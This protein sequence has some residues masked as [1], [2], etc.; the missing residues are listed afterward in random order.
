[1]TRQHGTRARYVR[2]PDENGQPGKGCRCDACRAANA[3]AER[4]K[5]RLRAYGRWRPLVDAGPVREH[6]AVLAGRGIKTKR[7]SQLS[8]ISHPAIVRIAE[9][10]T[11]RVRAQTA[12]A[13]L[14]VQPSPDLLTPR[15]HVDGAGT[16]RRLQALV[17]VGWTRSKL[18]EHI[19]IH[20]TNL[21]GIVT[22]D[23]VRADTARKVAA[24]YDALWD[25]QPPMGT[26]A[27]RRAAA[28]ARREAAEKGWLPPAAWDDDLIDL[29]DDELEVEL[30]RRV[31]AMDDAE[32]AR[33]HHA[34]YKLGELSPLVAAAARLYNA[35]NNRRRLA[36]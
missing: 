33:C 12:E 7:V 10:R 14:A 30:G 15:A 34:R 13:I 8:G 27:D 9:G 22:A 5:Y 6:L 4:E 18:A 16:R 28:A 26:P 23:S 3:T 35:R 29:C 31:A 20:H 21:C 36:A 11:V 24:A 25:R 2:G 32:L 1:M 17:A 19:G